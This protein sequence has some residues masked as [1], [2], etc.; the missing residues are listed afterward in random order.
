M[1]KERISS[2]L[3]A[4]SCVATVAFLITLFLSMR[5]MIFLIENYKVEPIFGT[6]V[7]VTIFALQMGGLIYSALL[8]YKSSLTTERFNKMKWHIVVFIIICLI[9]IGLVIVEFY[10]TQQELIS[11]IISVP[12]FI[13]TIILAIMSFFEN[14]RFLKRNKEI[15]D[16]VKEISSRKNVK[17]IDEQQKQNDQINVEEKECSCKQK[18]SDK[19]CRKELLLALILGVVFS[20]IGIIFSIYRVFDSVEYNCQ[21]QYFL[22]ILVLFILI[23]LLSL[24][25]E[26]VKQENILDENVYDMFN[27]LDYNWIYRVRK[28]DDMISL[29]ICYL[30]QIILGIILLIN[31]FSIVLLLVV[32]GVF[33]SGVLFVRDLRLYPIKSSE[34]SIEKIQKEIIEER[35]A[36]RLKRK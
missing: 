32:I 17:N 2:I 7:F 12:L 1:K 21:V 31:L 13:A 27:F 30:G 19:I 34:K 6:I 23:V 3:I 26:Y 14:K 29:F 16:Y 20:S 9:S 5:A 18:N 36:E 33:V 11:T 22:Y 24:K 35:E 8:K 28:I 25:F 10:Y 4:V 15:Q